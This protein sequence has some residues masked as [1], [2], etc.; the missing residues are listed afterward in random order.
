MGLP[1]RFNQ[2]YL[3]DELII[4]QNSVERQATHEDGEDQ[5]RI[6]EELSGA[7]VEE[8]VDPEISNPYLQACPVIEANNTN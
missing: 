3:S 4:E 1:E 8:L 2:R 7:P 5:Q 6:G